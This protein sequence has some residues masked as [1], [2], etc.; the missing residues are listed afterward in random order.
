[1]S[2]LLVTLVIVLITLILASCSSAPQFYLC[3]YQA[4]QAIKGYLEYPSTFD[5]HEMKTMDIMMDESIIEGNKE[6][7]WSIQ[8]AVFFGVE[9]GFG[10]KSDYVAA[11][12]VQVDSEGNCGYIDILD[13]VPDR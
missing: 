11:Y 10:V 1:M 6:D 8:T 9:N 13:I 3:S 2:K 7:G 5:E 4:K 12:R